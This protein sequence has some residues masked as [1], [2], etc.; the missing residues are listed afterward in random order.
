MD[1]VGAI[2]DTGNEDGA[3]GD[4]SH[5]AAAAKGKDD[6]DTGAIYDTGA[7]EEA[8]EEAE[9]VAPRTVRNDAYEPVDDP[10]VFDMKKDTGYLMTGSDNDAPSRTGTMK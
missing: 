5:G 4:D 7:A 6:D 10:A 3:G 1:Q 2:Y 8:A 9:D